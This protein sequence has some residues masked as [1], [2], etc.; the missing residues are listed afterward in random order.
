MWMEVFS[1]V[2]GTEV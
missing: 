2:P 1:V